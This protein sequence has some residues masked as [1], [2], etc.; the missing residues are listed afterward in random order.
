MIDSIPRAN[1][2][3]YLTPSTVQARNAGFDGFPAS[4]AFSLTV[5]FHPVVLQCLRRFFALD[6]G[7]N[8]TRRGTMNTSFV[9][10]IFADCKKRIQEFFVEKGRAK[11]TTGDLSIRKYG[12]MMD[13]TE[14]TRTSDNFF[15]DAR[16]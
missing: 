5:S 8:A 14:I 15:C 16:S 4:G 9:D 7:R 10:R 1:A 3:R 13:A 2:H 11:V 12:L 6:V